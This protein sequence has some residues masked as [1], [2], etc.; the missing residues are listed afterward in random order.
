MKNGMDALI[1]GALEFVVLKELCP[2][3]N[4]P[5]MEKNSAVVPVVKTMEETRNVH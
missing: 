4:L 1:R 2:V 5:Q 3:T